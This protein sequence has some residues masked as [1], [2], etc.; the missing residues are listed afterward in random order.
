MSAPM[1]MWV[2][3]SPGAD[4][5]LALQRLA[6]AEDVQHVAV[7][8]DVHLANAVCVGTATATTH[9]ILPEAVG[10]DSG[11][12]MLAVRFDAPASVLGSA[13][14][15]AAVL[16]G[17]YRTIP[18]IKHAVGSA[19]ELPA[20]LVETPLSAP[21]LEKLKHR[22]GRLEL[23]TLGRGNHFLEFQRDDSNGLWLMLHS[24]S[25]AMG[26]AI[27]EHHL[28]SAHVD[29]GLRWLDAGSDEGGRYL[30]DVAWARRYARKGSRVSFRARWVRR[31][32][33]WS[34]AASWQRSARARTALDAA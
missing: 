5:R 19:P 28:R 29:H 23:G 17:L 8:P 6:D 21:A 2:A 1:K 27:R 3:E 12:G 30:A 26:P 9:R 20:A 15:A 10:G 31:A 7:M 11:C 4:V 16:S 24:G 25:R 34:G 18:F 22:D 13:K 32:I 14:T 33:T